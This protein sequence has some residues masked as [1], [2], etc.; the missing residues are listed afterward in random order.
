MFDEAIVEF[1]R[2]NV[3]SGLSAILAFDYE[4]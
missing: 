1:P 2:K 4:K 3:W